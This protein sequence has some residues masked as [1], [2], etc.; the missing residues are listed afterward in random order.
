[1][2]VVEPAPDAQLLAQ[3]P[4]RTSAGQLVQRQIGLDAGVVTV[5]PGL[6]ADFNEVDHRCKPRFNRQFFPQD[7]WLH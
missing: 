7:G 5:I 6:H 3:L 2:L 1:M 4:E